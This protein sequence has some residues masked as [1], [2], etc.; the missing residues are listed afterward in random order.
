MN[1]TTVRG[2]E[3]PRPAH[4]L[5]RLAVVSAAAVFGGVCGAAAASQPPLS[6]EVQY[7]QESQRV[8]VRTPFGDPQMGSLMGIHPSN[9]LVYENGRRQ[10]GISVVLEHAPVSLGILVEYGGRYH[11]INEILGAHVSNAAQALLEELAPADSATVWK[12]ADHLESG[13][14]DSLGAEASV[15]A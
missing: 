7:T 6:A 15:A 13:A 9:F 1:T 8:T 5:P 11:A 3:P 14:T 12:Y 2:R 10:A 4:L